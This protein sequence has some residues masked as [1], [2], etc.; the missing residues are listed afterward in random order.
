MK[1][2][3]KPAI[4]S[5]HDVMPETLS[6]V[7]DI[8][9][10]PLAGF[11]RHHITLLVVPGRAW[12]AQSL[13]R[14]RRLR[15]LG[16]VLAGHGWSHRVERFGGVYHRWHSLVLSRR[17]AEHL[18]LKPAELRTLLARNGQWFRDNGLG[19]PSLYVPPAWAMGPLTMTDLKQSPFRVVE[20][21]QGMVHVGTGQWRRLPVVGF[22]AD[23]VW[24][25]ALLTA[26]NRLAWL[27]AGRNRPLRI[28]IHPSDFQLRLA[29]TLPAFL[30]GVKSVSWEALWRGL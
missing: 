3:T 26:L 14:L 24:R 25:A 1:R 27:C 10:G 7:E 13:D 18:S 30:A 6:L 19:Q 8:L 20:T 17:A 21:L 4:I 5:V 12:T 11:S 9:K 29:S 15:A 2:K 28:A 23:T 22:E 16:Y